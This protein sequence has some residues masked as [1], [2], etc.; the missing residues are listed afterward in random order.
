MVARWRVRQADLAGHALPP[1]LL[2]LRIGGHLGHV[3]R[4]GVTYNAANAT[5]ITGGT[6]IR[7][8]MGFIADRELAALRQQFDRLRP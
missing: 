4:K 7:D 8:H 2:R 3:G 5:I 6:G 1:P